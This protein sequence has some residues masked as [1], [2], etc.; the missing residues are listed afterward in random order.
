MLPPRF[1][2]NV[3]L[4]KNFVSNIAL[5]AALG[6]AALISQRAGAQT[7]AIAPRI[8]GPID[9]SVL[10]TL[11][12]NVP[13]KARTEFD[14]G[15]AP[16]VTELNFIRLVLSRSPEQEAALEKFMAQQLDKSSPNYRHWLTPDQFEKLYGPADSDIAAIVAWVQSHGMKVESVSTGR[17]NIAFSGT[18]SQVE[19]TFHTSIH[20]FDDHAEQ[21]LSNTSDPSIPAALAPVVSGVAQLNT[22]R[23]KSY[24]VPGR[25]GRLDPATRRL[26]PA[27][28]SSNGPTP[29]F[30]FG[31]APAYSLFLVPADAAT[32]YDTP[33]TLN[34]NFTSA[35]GAPYD[36]TGVTIGIVGDALIQATTVVDY[37]T[38][39]LNNTTAPTITNVAPA[40][41]TGTD[42]D[43]G[44]LDVEI[45]GGLAPGAGIVFYT[46]NDLQT[47]INQAITD[48]K[49][50]ILSVSFGECELSLGTSGNALLKGY[51]QQA[52][53]A[54]IS[55]VVATGDSGSANC[56]LNNP[57]TSSSATNGL[58]VSGFASTPYDIAVG[59]TDY[60]SLVTG[61]TT[62]VNTANG[63]LYGSAKGYIPEVAWNQSTTL[64]T[65][66]S[67]N[68]PAFDRMNN[69]NIVA[70]GGGA[71]ACSTNTTT[72]TV[73][74][75][76]TRGYPKPSWQRGAGVPNDGE[77]DIP[78]VS[79][80]AGAGMDQA[81]WLVCTD[82]TFTQGG[83]TYTE[84][85]TGTQFAFAPFGGTSASAPAFAGMLALVQQK[86]GGRLG[87][88]AA[89]TLYDLFN[90]SQPG[91][92]FHDITAG[93][94]SVVCTSGT[95]NC[96][97]N[98]AGNYFLTGYDVN[99]AGYNLATGMGSVDVTQLVNAW[100]T[101]TGSGT[102]TMAITP[103]ATAITSLQGLTVTIVVTGTLGIPTGTVSLSGGGYGPSSTSLD[104]TG[105]A[106]F[107]VAVGVLQPSVPPNGDI[108][109]A[110][111]S[112][113]L[114]Y[115]TT[116]TSTTVTVTQAGFTLTASTPAS[117]TPGVT[118][119][120]NITVST[121]NGYAGAVT[122]NCVIAT[123]PSGAADVPACTI[124]PAAPITLGS[125][126]TSGT[127]TATFITTPPIASLERPHIGG[128]ESAG[129]ALLALMVFFGIPAHRRNWRA[130]VGLVVVAVALV[131]ISACGS[132]TTTTSGGGPNSNPGTTA[133]T[134]TYALSGT[135]TPAYTPPTAT[136]TLTVN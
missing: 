77:R 8:T 85:C 101:A 90:G 82:D 105:T 33:N 78:D 25:A 114:D 1:S 15:E 65:T 44:Y 20:L 96:A 126:A 24:N 69:T 9:E 60:N 98:A 80:F 47:A 102:A 55:V 121:S 32:I 19:Q 124:T 86:V 136:I 36:G 130:L 76:C 50:D 70:G 91:T 12:G 84:N 51:W 108:L 57:T 123:M 49:V 107:T 27:D 122:L 11:R 39:F 42:T 125:G 66:L 110:T 62:Y 54:G 67:A 118:V 30:T 111:Y 104:A 41:A 94:N 59:G 135:G 37:R 117:A 97:A 109:T 58:Q 116:T 48:N 34:A 83:T 127:A 81:A 71:S 43:E 68:I 17:T 45:A 113:D 53:A 92:V 2:S 88:V 115:A 119:T 5:S 13:P 14:K 16:P 10:T 38:Q 120:S 23:P 106:S 46:S 100:A 6:I 56:D 74:G 26:V 95:P 21:F 129:G 28:G 3:F 40:A 4:S 7:A 18:V 87:G 72:P 63:T 52:S 61:F 31:T 64:D 22:I 112:G 89:Q 29:D 73:N 103:S 75:T 93:N 133:G 132:S 35:S 128:W 131:S 99:T 79:L 134:Y